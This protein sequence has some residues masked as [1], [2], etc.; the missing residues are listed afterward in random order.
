MEFC[1][2][3]DAVRVCSRIVHDFVVT[4]AQPSRVS[5]TCQPLKLVRRVRLR[6]AQQWACGSDVVCAKIVGGLRLPVVEHAWPPG[7]LVLVS[8]LRYVEC[9]LCGRV[10][11]VVS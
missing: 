8:A 11:V 3:K 10:H 7:R 9:G 1:V 5:E 2:W 4:S 6:R